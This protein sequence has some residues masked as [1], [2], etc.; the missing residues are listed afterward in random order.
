MRID[1][2]YKYLESSEFIENV[3]DKNIAKIERRLKIFRK[4][5]PIHISIHLEKN[6]HR[7]QYFCRAHIYLPSPKTLAAGDKGVDLSAAINKTFSAIS[8]Q[9]E[10]LKYKVE[11]HLRR[12]PRER[13][14]S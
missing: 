7:E 11:R 5:D 2:S 12:K 14:T 8:K 1:V 9:L 4:D 3:I 10:K 13:L 6:P